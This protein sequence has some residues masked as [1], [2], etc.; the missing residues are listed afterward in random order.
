MKNS[1]STALLIALVMLAVSC[2]SLQDRASRENE[3]AV[4]TIQ[5]TF[6]SY[7]PLHFI[8]PKEKIKKQAYTKLLEQ[9]KQKYQGNIDIA[10]ITIKGSFSGWSL[11]TMAAGGFIG[12]G[13][14][15]G[16][17]LLTNP[18]SR[19][20]VDGTY[21][22]HD[23]EHL[24]LQFAS[25]A[26]GVPI[27]V[28]L[29]GNF[30][31]ITATGDIVATGEYRVLSQ[32]SRNRPN[33]RTTPLQR[34]IYNASDSITVDLPKGAKIAL[35]NI[36]SSDK[37]TAEQVIDELEYIFVSSKNFTMVNRRTLDAIMAEQNFQLSGNVDDNGAV[38][39]GK[40]TGANIVITGAVS[41]SGSS[42]RLTLRALD[43]Q[44]GQIVSM[45]R[46]TF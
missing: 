28:F 36:E 32:S 3:E 19:D 1:V 12:G 31:K 39:I 46:E 6:T 23:D 29:S 26:I 8:I 27:G 7:Q 21:L 5:V 37:K 15:N 14:G 30:Q 18:Q 16:I 35:L 45:A 40:M 11:L 34:A 4:E 24:Q 20:P 22:P 17:F 13:L 2:V 38:S 9:A 25:I 41:G 43:V 33:A 44:T 10:N 42:R